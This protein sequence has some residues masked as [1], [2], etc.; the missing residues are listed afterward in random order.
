MSAG[1][2]TQNGGTVSGASVGD[3]TGSQSTYVLDAGTVTG[4][5]FVGVSG[6]GTFT[7][8]GGTIPNGGLVVG[9]V[10][11]TQSVGLGGGILTVPLDGYTG[12]TYRLQRS[13]SLAASNYR[14]VGTAQTDA[15]GQTLTF[16]DSV[17]GGAQ[18]FYRVQVDP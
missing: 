6:T 5:I 10:I 7:Q 14:N 8:N 13:D 17:A 3:N 1:T 18:G 9:S 2:F 11:K 12:H 15:T 16:T 4:S